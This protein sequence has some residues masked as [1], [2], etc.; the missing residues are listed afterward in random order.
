MHFN[1][2]TGFVQRQVKVHAVFRGDHTVFAGGEQEC[3]RGLRGD[4]KFVREFLDQLR[5][6]IVTDEVL[7]RTDI[8]IGRFES[9][10]RI[11]QD[12]KIRSAAGVIDRVRCPRVPAVE[13]GCGGR[14]QM[15]ACLKAHHSDPIQ[16]DIEFFGPTAHQP[17]RPLRISQFD[18]VMVTRPQAVLEDESGNAHGIE[19]VRHLPAFVVGGETSIS[20]AWRNNDRRTRDVRPP[21]A[22]QREG[23]LSSSPCPNAPGAPFSHNRTVCVS[24]VGSWCAWPRAM[25]AET[26][27][28]TMI[29]LVRLV[30]SNQE[31]EHSLGPRI[32]L[33]L[34]ARRPLRIKTCPIIE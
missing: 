25:A 28:R 3:G 8:A 24:A 22:I 34:V 27:Q 30:M 2:D 6:R 7:G 18:G 10:D 11:S 13:V 17:D 19:P 12:D 1:R 31:T 16:Q 26:R 29:V 32:T 21:R 14:S 9:Y 5:I 15:P 20:A 4:V 23:G 33:G